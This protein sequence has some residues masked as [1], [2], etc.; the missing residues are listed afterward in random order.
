MPP[1][2]NTCS[3]SSWRSAGAPRP[4]VRAIDLVQFTLALAQSAIQYRRRKVA[5]LILIGQTLRVKGRSHY[6]APQA[7]EIFKSLLPLLPV[8]PQCLFEAFF[9]LHFLARYGHRKSWIFG[10]H[11]FPFRAHCWIAEDDVLLNESPHRIEGYQVILTAEP[12]AS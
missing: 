5:E 7:A 3:E 12:T 9:L 11:L 1:V 2:E 10:A 6:T 8:R 4:A